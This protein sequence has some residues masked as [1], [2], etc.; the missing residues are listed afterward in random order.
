[1]KINLLLIAH[2]FLMALTLS[3]SFIHI[4]VMVSSEQISLKRK[5]HI[6]LFRNST[7]LLDVCFNIFSNTHIFTTDLR[8]KKIISM[9][10]IME[11]PV[12]SP[13]VPPMRLSWA[14]VLIFLSLLMSSKVAVLKKICTNCRVDEG[15]SFP[16]THI[17]FLNTNFN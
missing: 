11:K 14:S 16:E 5:K 17:Q 1:M 3:F 12:R 13:M 2:Y 8:R 10:L 6:K 9:P 4:L 15:S 7:T